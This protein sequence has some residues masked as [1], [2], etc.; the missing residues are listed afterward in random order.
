MDVVVV[1]VLP[2]QEIGWENIS[3]FLCRMGRKTLT[4]NLLQAPAVFS[5]TVSVDTCDH[6][7]I[8]VELLKKKSSTLEFHQKALPQGYTMI[9]NISGPQI[10]S[11]TV[12]VDTCDHQSVGVELLK[13]KSSTLDVQ[14]KALP[15]GYRMIAE[16]SGP[17]TFSETVSVDTEDRRQVGI[18][19]LK[20]KTSLM[21]V[22]R[23]ALPQ[24]VKVNFT[25]FLQCQ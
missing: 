21:D 10:F 24:G 9:A 3:L 17:Q 6:Q 11:E 15:Q 18:E 25:Q 14:Q 5:E 1:A 13:K 12:S 20:K 7:S 2:R 22:E 4:C 16:V 23:H 8:G 19:L